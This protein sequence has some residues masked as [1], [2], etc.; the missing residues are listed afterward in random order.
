[1]SAPHP[2]VAPLIFCFLIHIYNYTATHLL[3]MPGAVQGP[4][5]GVAVTKTDNLE[6]YFM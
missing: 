1:M 4:G 2:T 5:Q 6:L 3:T